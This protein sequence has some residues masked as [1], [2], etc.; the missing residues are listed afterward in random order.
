MADPHHL[1]QN[2][3]SVPSDIEFFVF[4]LSQTVRKQNGIR[5]VISSKSCY[6][7]IS[8]ARELGR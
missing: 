8:I 3:V 2:V 5:K 7:S 4:Q 1:S 6:L